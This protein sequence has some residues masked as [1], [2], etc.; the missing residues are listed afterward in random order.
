M[1]NL[2]IQVNAVEPFAEGQTFGE[3]GPYLRIRGVAKG[4]LDLAA[5]ENRVIVDLDKAPRNARGLVEYETDFFIMRPADPARASGMLVY[6]VTNRG[7]KRIFQLLDDAPGDSP[8]ASNDPKTA[9]EAGLGFLL[10]R[11]YSLVWSGW[12]PGAPSAN[13]GLGA[14]FPTAIE[15]GRPV[16]GY[17]RHEFHIGTRAPG[18]GDLV[19]L[20]YPAVS[21]DQRPA[22]LTVRDRE[23][24]G[25]TEIPANS[26]E[27]ADAQSIRLLPQGNPFAPVKIYELWY[28]ATGAKVL[29]IGFATV[30]DLVS[31][32]GYER[33]DRNGTPNPLVAEGVLTEGTGIRHALAF[34]VSQSGR[35]LRHLLEL[36]MKDDGRAR[37]SKNATAAERLMSPKS[38]R[39]L[40]R[41][42]PSGCYC[43]PT[44]RPMSKRRRPATGFKRR[45]RYEGSY[46][47]S[48][49]AFTQ[50]RPTRV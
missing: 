50:R 31:F 36:G 38:K 23:S 43:L 48:A 30:R 17:I 42:S 1:T 3:A 7:S 35:F 16:T 6:D 45:E 32:L 24:D 11:G 20:S 9:R 37:R 15:N 14:R 41:S 5:P 2:E 12:D 29:G 13:N 46:Q 22:R 8:A 34:G 44:P 4:E 18:T 47:G 40:K 33:T 28:E 10:G 19:R 49:G 21:T 27:F 26:W 25:R 39:G